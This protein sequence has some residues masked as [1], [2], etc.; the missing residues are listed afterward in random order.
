MKIPGP[1][2]INA[3]DF[4]YNTETNKA[5]IDAFEK[6]LSSSTTIMANMPG[7]EE[8][9]DLIHE[10][11]LL[12]H[13]GIHLVITEGT[14]LTNQIMRSRRFCNSQGAFNLTRQNR[15]FRLQTSEKALLARELREQIKKCRR[16]KIPITHADSHKNIH[17]EWAI[18][19]I[20]MKICKEEQVSWVRLARN[21]G[22]WRTR[23]NRAYRHILN[24]RL[25]TAGMTRTRYF[26]SAI[27]CK[28]FFERN[29]I[30]AKT[31][32]IEVM[33]HP[34]YKKSSL[35]DTILKVELAKSIKSIGY[36]GKIVSYTGHTWEG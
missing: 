1:I 26:G 4:G 30:T 32:S 16:N 24:F 18:A 13:T 28:Y 8:A 2:I 11:G 36:N 31:T 34:A 19:K 12:H 5:I 17:E 14:P 33:T 3:D 9:C 23:Y 25:K 29:R 10:R 15:I 35:V 27:D 22:K 20:V 6:R 21:C 7:F